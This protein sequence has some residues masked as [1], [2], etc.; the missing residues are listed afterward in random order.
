MT[1]ALG[2]FE[3]G[4]PAVDCVHSMF[5]DDEFPFIERRPR[6]MRS[7]PAEHEQVDAFWKLQAKLERH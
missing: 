7:L 3:L 4:A 6:C 5:H 1:D 2:T